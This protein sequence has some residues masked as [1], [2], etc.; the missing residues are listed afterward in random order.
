[1]DRETC[2]QSEVMRWTC[3]E[4]VVLTTG[5]HA[6]PVKFLMVLLVNE[7]VFLTALM[8]TVGT[9]DFFFLNTLQ[10]KC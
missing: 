4:E 10:K 6:D 5:R 8:S 1:M 3:E 2:H 9:W 7:T